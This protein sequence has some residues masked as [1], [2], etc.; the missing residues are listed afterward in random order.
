MEGDGWEN[1]ALF[2]TY[3][4]WNLLDYPAVEWNDTF[5][6]DVSQQPAGFN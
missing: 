3:G 5:K 4:M 2:S 1:I 6:Q